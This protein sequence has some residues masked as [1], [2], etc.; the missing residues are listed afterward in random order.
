MNKVYIF[1]MLLILATLIPTQAARQR[2]SENTQLA[3]VSQDT[4]ELADGVE[5][6][7][8]DANPIRDNALIILEGPESWVYLLE[9]RPTKVISSYLRYIKLGTEL[10]SLVH[11]SNCRAEI[12]RQGCVVIPQNNFYKP[13][14][15]FSETDFGGSSES[16]GILTY[17]T[18]L[19]AMTGAIRSFKL[20]KGYMATLATAAD[21]TGFSRVFIADSEDLEI[22]Q[23]Q[24]ELDQNVAYIRVFQWRWPSQKGWCWGPNKA[25]LDSVQATW[26]YD[27]DANGMDNYMDAEYVP[28]RHNAGWQ[29]FSVI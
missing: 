5:L 17:H 12:Y 28:M 1:G 8:T 15:A 3:Y 24:V 4:I 10:A 16:Y 6:R 14:E 29:S 22:P 25:R 13:F 27:W 9:V 26:Y 2:I 7:L 23:L 11:R 20:K 18:N 19:G 21:G